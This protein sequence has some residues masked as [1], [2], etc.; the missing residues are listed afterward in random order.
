MASYATTVQ[1]TARLSSMYVLPA[2][3]V[4]LLIKASELIDF[5]TMGRAQRAYDAAVDDPDTASLLADA[6]CDQV[7]YWLEVGE[8]HD[9]T[10]LSGA[11]QG[12]RVQIQK[13]PPYLGQRALRTL[14]RAGLYY[15]GVGSL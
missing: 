3:A 11:L 9:I 8:E 7:E 5:A 14:L 6:T 13:L 15:A 10:G 4:G 12:G 1:L 2:D